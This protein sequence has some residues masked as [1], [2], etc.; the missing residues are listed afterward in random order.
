MYDK[1]SQKDKP[2]TKACSSGKINEYRLKGIKETCDRGIR[3]RWWS[4]FDAWRADKAWTN[5]LIE[6]QHQ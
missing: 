5:T 4:E 1:G 3:S 2:R 6:H